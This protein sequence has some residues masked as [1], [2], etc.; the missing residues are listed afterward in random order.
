MN[1]PRRNL[2]VKARL[3]HLEEA[4][5]IVRDLCGQPP[6]IEL[7]TDTYFNTTQ[8]RLKLREIACG[9]E[10]E[11]VLIAY[12]RADQAETRTCK[13]HLVP[14]A[15]PALLKTALTSTLGVCAVVRKR[16]EISIHHNVR[17]HLDE[18]NGLGTFL[19]LEAVLS[20]A[21]DENVSQARLDE[22]LGQLKITRDDF[23]AISYAELLDA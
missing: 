15:D 17:I 21:D 14:V 18:V 4:R 7:Q 6:R 12:D 13:Y 2:E 9:D 16:R 3:A 11:S 20:S 23:L 1:E 8:G 10:A 5:G 22:L 19:E